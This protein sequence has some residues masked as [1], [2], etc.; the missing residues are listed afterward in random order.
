MKTIKKMKKMK[1]MK[2]IKQKED[3]M[4]MMMMMMMM[5]TMTLERPLQQHLFLKVGSYSSVN[6]IGT[7][8]VT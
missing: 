2:K 5:M 1:N 8:D 7:G 4:M 6:S 3:I